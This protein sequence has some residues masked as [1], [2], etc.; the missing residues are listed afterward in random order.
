MGIGSIVRSRGIIL[1]SLV[2]V[3]W[4]LPGL[5]NTASADVLSWPS[6][7][8]RPGP[9]S[10]PQGEKLIAPTSGRTD[11]LGVAHLTYQADPGLEMMIPPKGLTASEVTPALMAD[12]GLYVHQAASPAAAQHLK[13]QVL[14]LAKNRTAPEF[15]LSRATNSS[16]SRPPNAINDHN[17]LTNWA[18]YAKGESEEGS[19]IN[20]VEGDWFVPQSMT[21]GTTSAEST[22]VG[23]GGSNI[24]EGS[25]VNGLIQAGTEMQTG[26]GYRYFWE[27]IG[28]SGCVNTFCGLYSSK[29]A[30]GPGD[31][32][33]AEVT[34]KDTTDA[35]FSLNDI[36][37]GIGFSGCHPVN[38][39][40]DHTSAEWINERP[41][42][43]NYYDSPGTVTWTSQN[44]T[45]GLNGSGT[46]HSPFSGS[47]DAIVMS[48]TINNGPFVC[49][50]SLPITSYPTGA[51][52]DGSGGYSK[53]LTCTINGVDSP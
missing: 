41:G 16:G 48:S 19:G 3:A 36:E 53:T 44:L 50:G 31:L 47:F 34:W 46:W 26:S 8:A 40:Y 38:I 10:C 1:L 6:Q 20:G 29:D 11:T 22:W 45:D 23:V 28:S 21:K 51:S 12:V 32:I 9:G 7:V 24:F 15:C 49:D 27:Y 37:R 17:E 18:G 39:P 33:S 35:C 14:Y 25:N 52:N 5:V 43:F 2:A 30:I 4:G 42:G 13:Q